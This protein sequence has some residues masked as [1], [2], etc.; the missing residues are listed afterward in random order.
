MDVSRL[1]AWWWHRQG[2][3]GSLAGRPAGEILERAGWARSVGGVGPYLTLFS[4]GGIGRGAVDAAVAALEI[5]E[6]PAARGCTYVIP[7]ADFALA[8][9]VGQG[10]NGDMA[11]ARRIGVTD[12]EVDRL[13]GKLVDVLAKGP[14]DPEELREAA[15]GAV[16]SLGEE[17][18]KKGLTTTL[19]LALG[20]L[21]AEGD[22]RRV[23]TNGR[24]D[25]QRYRYAIW[26]PNPLA[27]CPLSAEDANRELARRFF[28]WI[29]PA[30]PAEF[31]SFSGLGVKAAKAALEPLR[32]VGCPD[33]GER[34]LLPEDRALYDRFK[35]ATGPQYALVSSLDGISLLRRDIATLLDAADAKRKA[36]G[37]HAARELGG[38]TDLPNHAIL[39]RGRLVG[40]WEFDPETASIVWRAFVKK[41][42][43]LKDA[44]ARTEIFVRDDLGDARSFSL[45]SPKSRA[46]R[47]EALRRAASAGRS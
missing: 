45:D 42:K 23:P 43:A 21:Q 10:F 36:A 30:S 11:T 12:K 28:R 31:Q 29:A 20:R 3:D 26:R 33:A 5:H 40:L 8:L 9:K 47:I 4:R 34:L 2:L 39:D 16:R 1:R 22:I 25:Q 19:P 15:G 35:A 27:S 32:L 14:L 37:T 24:L 18:R 44:V 41:D 17:G 13:C 46:P 6:L 7:A 38:L